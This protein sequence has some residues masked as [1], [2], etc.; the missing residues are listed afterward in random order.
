MNNRFLFYHS[1][2]LGQRVVIDSLNG[3]YRIWLNPCPNFKYGQWIE[4]REDGIYEVIHQQGLDPRE[5]LLE[6][7]NKD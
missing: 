7:V 3:A 1:R 2:K 5:R 4:L 6:P